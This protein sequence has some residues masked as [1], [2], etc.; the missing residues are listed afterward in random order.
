MVVIFIIRRAKGSLFFALM[1]LQRCTQVGHIQPALGWL[2]LWKLINFSTGEGHVLRIKPALHVPAGHRGHV[3]KEM[4]H[5]NNRPFSMIQSG[6]KQW[7]VQWHNWLTQKKKELCWWLENVQ[8]IRPANLFGNL[9]NFLSQGRED[10]MCFFVGGVFNI[11][12]FF[13]PIFQ[14]VSLAFTYNSSESP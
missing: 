13:S 14:K 1:L 10:I 12:Q 9:D 7:L 8:I 4:F 5:I 3:S 11:Q 2:L 6:W